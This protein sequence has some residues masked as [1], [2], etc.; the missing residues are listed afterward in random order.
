MFTDLDQLVASFLEILSGIS[1]YKGFVFV[2]FFLLV[3]FLPSIVA[4]F[5][6]RKH[7]PKI[8]AANVPAT[9]SWIAWLALLAWAFT[10]KRRSKE[11]GEKLDV[12]NKSPIAEGEP[13]IK[14]SS[15]RS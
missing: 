10:G 12:Q 5:F 1:A 3:C 15:G 6:N 2:T 7:F 14:A 9:L 11:K 8:V 4:F 13:V